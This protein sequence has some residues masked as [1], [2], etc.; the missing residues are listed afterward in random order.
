[1]Q[2][3][4]WWDRAAKP[5]DVVRLTA[6][7]TAGQD[8]MPEAH[9]ARAVVHAMQAR[10]EAAIAELDLA[11][12]LRGWWESAVLYK[13]QI[14]VQNNKSDDAVAFLRQAVEA[15]PKQL[16]FRQM[17]A[18]TL[19]ELKRP[20][21][22]RQA[23]QDILKIA[24]ANL[25]ALQGAG[26]L[27]LQEYD[28]EA[29]YSLLS[30]ALEREPNNADQLRLYLGQIEEERYRFREALALYQQIGGE[31]KKDAAKRI[32]RLLARQGERE[33]AL[34][35]V[36]ALPD[37]EAAEKI[38]KVQ[39]LAQVWRE[40]KNPAQ[41]RAVLSQML[42]QQPDSVDLL[43]DRALLADHM[44]DV[45][46]AEQDL[47]RVLQLQ[48]DHVQ[49]LNALGYVLVS[50]TNRL[51]EAEALLQ[52]AF[53]AEP[54]NPVIIDSMGWLRF[55]QGE[56]DEALVLLG[57]AYGKLHDPE[58]AA[59]YAEALWRSGNTK[60]ARE[61]L[62]AGQKLDPAHPAIVETRKRLGF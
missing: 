18:R 22:A 9:F 30:A 44:E 54:E 7:L 62:A 32:P 55:R 36:A 1:M 56:L 34:K 43:Y 49:A 23:Y 15:A 10:P 51:A 61:V 8:A 4:L 48:P 57:R 40:L 24:P 58:V 3:H 16:A 60:K 47:R 33:A 14:L 6:R 13:A 29:A 28:T 37:A 45:V 35:A 12:E 42:A 26:L 31:E 11:L 5:Q 38:E 41:G 27:A 2:L 19:A 21:Q 25:Q 20:A 39:I 46:A 50:R 53:K 59:H 17:L 52:R